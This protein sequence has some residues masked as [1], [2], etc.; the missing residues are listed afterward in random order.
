MD[1]VAKVSLTDG[2][3]KK[4]IRNNQVKLRFKQENLI[5]NDVL[6]MGKRDMN[7]LLKARENG[8]GVSL[9]VKLGST[10]SIAGQEGGNLLGLAARFAPMAAKA[11]GLAGL[12]FG[13]E[14]ALGK[15]FGKGMIPPKAIE[16]GKLVD[17]L[18]PAQKKMIK[19]ILVG[20]GY[21]GAGAG[22]KGGF[23]GILASLGIPLA[24]S[25]VKKVL[26][27]GMSLQPPRGRGASRSGAGMRLEPPPPIVGSW[28]EKKNSWMFP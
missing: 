24:I 14:K 25:L 27:S 17:M 2:Q 22:Q 1:Q 6:L 15:I 19:N 23:L 18:T 12:S 13:A 5:G 21:V 26:G 28:N 3:R 20:Q 11:L 8:K 7:K 9:L 10:A 4:L 16:L